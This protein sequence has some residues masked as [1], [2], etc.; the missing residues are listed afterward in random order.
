VIGFFAVL[1]SEL[2]TR[3][4]LLWKKEQ[5]KEATTT[6]TTQHFAWVT[7]ANPKLR[8]QNFKSLKLGKKRKIDLEV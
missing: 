8:F 3:E 6:T 2:Y 4:H 1:N 5:N 7:T